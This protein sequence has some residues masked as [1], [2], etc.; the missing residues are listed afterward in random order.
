MNERLI[1]RLYT[2][3]DKELGMVSC[4]LWLIVL[5]GMG[6]EMLCLELGG[7]GKIMGVW[8]VGGRYGI[9]IG[10]CCINMM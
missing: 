10:S 1:G 2:G 4:L 3:L 5:E 8:D 7:K 6:D 9:G